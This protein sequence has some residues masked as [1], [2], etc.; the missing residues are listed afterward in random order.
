MKRKYFQRKFDIRIYE[1]DFQ[2]RLQALSLFNFMQELAS[3][4]ADR[5]GFS[6]QQLMQKQM[7]WVLSRLHLKLFK[8][9]YWKDTL[10]GRTW[11]SGRV[12]KYALR[13]FAFYNGQGELIAAATSSWMVIDLQHRRPL[14]LDDLFHLDFIRR[15]R[16]LP[17]DF[18]PLPEV[19]QTEEEKEFSVGF[20][21]LDMNRHVNH[22]RYISWAMESLPE[23]F[24][25]QH[26]PTEVEVSYRKEVFL[27]DQVISKVQSIIEEQSI[28]YYH[29]LF[30]KRSGEEIARF[31]TR[32]K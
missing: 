24:L 18:P 4:H 5:L 9:A 32:W 31:R 21:D 11:P 20:T 2:G 25:F 14:K 27:G 13:D 7:T 26:F 23:N 3:A 6:V 22:V 16:A 12:G 8:S 10:L 28:L 1:C 29:Q 17:D 19:T 15:Y 30:L